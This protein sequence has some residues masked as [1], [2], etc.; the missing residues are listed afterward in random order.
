MLPPGVV[1]FI[2]ACLICN[3]GI[4]TS[5]PLAPMLFLSIK[6]DEGEEEELVDIRLDENNIHIVKNNS[7]ITN[8]KKTRTK[9]NFSLS[10][11]S[12]NCRL[13]SLHTTATLFN[14]H[15]PL[16]SPEA[17]QYRARCEPHRFPFLPGEP[18]CYSL[19][20]WCSL[21]SLL[22]DWQNM[23]REREMKMLTLK[24]E[25]FL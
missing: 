10:L 11:E 3:A 25:C 18:S 4:Q 20:G 23:L 7:K 2:F 13:C 6:R 21:T 19:L 12:I 1:W 16:S 17:V 14:L 9:C 8:L 24:T 15:L 22:H 5:T